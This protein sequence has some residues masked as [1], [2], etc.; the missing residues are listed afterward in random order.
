[1]RRRGATRRGAPGVS[2]TR[3][4][5]DN[6]SDLRAQVAANTRGI[7]SAVGRVR[8]PRCSSNRRSSQEG[9]ADERR[10]ADV[11]AARYGSGIRLD[12]AEAEYSADLSR[13]MGA[14]HQ[15]AN[16][17]SSAASGTAGLSA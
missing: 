3:N 1:M 11:D 8:I 12:A 7:T 9:A 2:G 14:V 16:S 5:A 17:S 10:I 15:V 6:L 13:W 4:L